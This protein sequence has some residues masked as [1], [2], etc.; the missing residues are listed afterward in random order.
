MSNKYQF[1]ESRLCCCLWLTGRCEVVEEI[2]KILVYGAGV[3]GS[4]YAALFAEAGFPVTVLARGKRLADLQSNGLRYDK[5]GKIKRANVSVACK[6]DNMDKYDFIF[7]TVRGDQLK[8]ALLELKAN[9]SP[10]IVTMTNTIEKYADM[11]TL[12]VRVGSFLLFRERVEA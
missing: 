1:V 2:L 12:S 7:V 3:I 4:L 11:E 6:L 5:A 8:Q 9:I 10:N